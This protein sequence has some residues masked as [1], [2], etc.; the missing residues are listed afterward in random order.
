MKTPMKFRAIPASF[1]H[2]FADGTYSV[3]RGADPRIP[4]EDEAS[5]VTETA[6]SKRPRKKRM[7][8]PAAE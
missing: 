8:Q 4:P 6:A 3:G 1:G 2:R 5:H 7:T